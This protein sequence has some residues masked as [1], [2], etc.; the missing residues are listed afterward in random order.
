[1]GTGSDVER[2]LAAICG[3]RFARHAGPA[4]EVAGAPARFVAAPGTVEA[5]SAVMRLA[6]EHD[7]AL[8]PRGAG[9]KL[10]WGAP[11]ARLDVLV[12]TGRLAGV[13]HRP[14][15]EAVVEVG[16]GTPVR[17]IQAALGR[18]G[19]RL[20]LDPPSPGATIGGVV[21]ADESG[22]LRH[23][24]GTPC[25]QLVGVSY[26]DAEGRLRHSEGWGMRD[27]DGPDLNQ[28]LCGS[29]GALA[30]LVSATMRVQPA[31]L[32]RLWVLRSVWT[33]LEVHDLVRLVTGASVEP[34]AIEVD[35]PAHRA[36]LIPR[37]RS[38]QGPGTL[39]VLVEGGR[40]EVIERAE[41]LV[42]V[43]RGDARVTEEPP[44]WWHR[45]PFE[46]GEVALRLEVPISDLHAAIYA[47]R[48][49]VGG[50]VPV[51]GAAGVGVVHAALPSTLA[52]DRVAAILDA[53]R[54]VLLF[55]GG[56]CV[57][58]S[59]PAGVRP[60][61]DLWGQ[62]PAL[63]TLREVKVRFDPYG[64]LAPGRYVGGL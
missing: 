18:D 46:P 59:A 51:R 9:S 33:P 4:D 52:A 63:A 16:A 32:G 61:I 5:V 35:L 3:P 55:R 64:R 26:V 2:R 38:R 31:P 34:A 53:V 54:G 40:T 11:P 21:A 22:P 14:P 56:T 47:L 58:I 44:R 13:W 12:D 39:A 8:A 23:R 48:D 1:M 60:E 49:A 29:Q 7:L 17:A 25:E 41:R 15:G 42:P 43:L 27:P 20:P 36:A 19:L 37:Q 10:D 62:V 28:L 30:V 45:Y 6:A 24:H 57:V 50:P